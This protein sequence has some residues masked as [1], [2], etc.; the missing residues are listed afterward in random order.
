MIKGDP[1]ISYATMMEIRKFI[2]S[3]FPKLYA[4]P[5]TIA[6]RYSIFRRQFKNSAKEEIKVIDYQLQQDKIISRVAEYFAVTLGGKK[7]D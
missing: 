2:C 1:K 3:C 5:I 7:I 4:L 6:T